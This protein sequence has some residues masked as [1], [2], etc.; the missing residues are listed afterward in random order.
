[1]K[2]SQTMEPIDIDLAG[3]IPIFI[4]LNTLSKTFLCEG[5]Q[6]IARGVMFLEINTSSR[7]DIILVLGEMNAKFGRKGHIIP[8]DFSI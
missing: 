8:I 5:D 6:L 4:F 1:M 7:H 2:F 3:I